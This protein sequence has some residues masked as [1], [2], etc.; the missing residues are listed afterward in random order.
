MTDKLARFYTYA[1]ALLSKL[2]RRYSDSLKD[3]STFMDQ[4]EKFRRVLP[5]LERQARSLDQNQIEKALEAILEVRAGLRE[6]TQTVVVGRGHLAEADEAGQ[7]LVDRLATGA[8]LTEPDN[9]SYLLKGD[10]DGLAWHLNQTEQVTLKKALSKVSPEQKAM[11]LE[12]L[13]KEQK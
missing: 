9:L 1:T 2:G 6:I 10:S 7:R 3:A 8:H 5:E 13:L 4:V 11:I 12:V